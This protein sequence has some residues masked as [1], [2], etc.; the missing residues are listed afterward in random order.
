MELEE[1][2]QISE[3]RYRSLSDAAFEGIMISHKG[4][5]L[6]ANETIIKM[7]GYPRAGFVNRSYIDF[8]SPEDREN[9]MQKMLS[10]DE[11]LYESKIL[12][13]DGSF[14]PVEIRARMF[15]DKGGRM[16]RVTSILDITEKKRAE[17]EIKTL[18]GILPICMHCKEIRD[19][20][21]YWNR[22]EKY[23]S[24]HSEAEFSH[25]ICDKC[26]KKYY[27]HLVSD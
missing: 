3:K 23:I 14:L 7:L 5:I 8:L 21:G 6:D 10:G 24:E 11:K 9:V 18:K 1:K 4:Y 19:D 26:L 25:S 22:L 13:K 15:S 16:L 17:E 2:L 27:S 20:H 12:K